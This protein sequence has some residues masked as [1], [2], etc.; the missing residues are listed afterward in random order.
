ME[1]ART[2]RILLWRAFTC[3]VSIILCSASYLPALSRVTF[4]RPTGSVSRYS[5]G[6]IPIHWLR[7]LCHSLS[8][9]SVVLNCKELITLCNLFAYEVAWLGVDKML[10]GLRCHH[11]NR[12]IIQ[13]ALWMWQNIYISLQKCFSSCVTQNNKFCSMVFGVLWEMFKYD[14]VSKCCSDIW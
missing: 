3:L 2:W 13:I 8:D 14:G 6:S 9:M 4:L 11:M 5:L 12:S 1:H 10:V 7:S